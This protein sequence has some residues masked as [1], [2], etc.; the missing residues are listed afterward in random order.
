MDKAH[1]VMYALAVYGLLTMILSF[2]V[3]LGECNNFEE[4]KPDVCMSNFWKW[5]FVITLIIIVIA[6]LIGPPE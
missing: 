3:W 5:G 6:F 2:L 1:I 4:A